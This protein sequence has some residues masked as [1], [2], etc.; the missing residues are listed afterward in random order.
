[1]VIFFANILLSFLQ[2]IGDWTMVDNR[3]RQL[4]A[5]TGRRKSVVKK[6]NLSAELQQ[7]LATLPCPRTLL[8]CK[9][10]DLLRFLASKD[11]S[12]KGKTQIHDI[13]CPYLGQAKIQRCGC[14][15]RFSAESV[16]HIIGDLKSI[17]IRWGRGSDWDIASD[18]GNPAQST[19]LDMY[20]SAI[21]EEQAESHVIVKQ[22]R[23]MSLD[24]M[25]ALISYFSRELASNTLT[26][27]ETYL[28]LRDRA[29]FLTQFLL[30]ERGGD[31]S[32]LL[33][34]EIFSH[35]DGSGIIFRQTYGKTRVERH[36]VLLRSQ[37]VS[38]CPV[39]ALQDFV[40]Q[41]QD[42]GLDMSTGYVFRKMLHSGNVTN[43][44]FSQSAASARLKLHLTTIGRFQDETTHSLRSGCAVAMQSTDQSPGAVA[45]HIG[46]QSKAC[47][48][49]YSRANSFQSSA[50]AQSMA[51]LL[52][53]ATSRQMAD[54]NFKKFATTD[55]KKWLL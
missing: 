23:P 9:P 37:D 17:F 5:R 48:E 25:V 29:F 14:P 28:F 41:S 51:S 46:W 39:T 30:G 19:E 24:K 43:A 2:Q 20:L 8:D 33:L 22:A 1:M 40:R 44:P 55:L 4:A 49:R 31:L 52:S 21:R 54:S 15:C 38:L 36:C 34:Q 12:G 6:C 35:P 13:E 53:S 7:F 47:W 11:E 16:R 45:A 3:L 32:K 18:T 42:M 50:V 10:A 26:L 27:K